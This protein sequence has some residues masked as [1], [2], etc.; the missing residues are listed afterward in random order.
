MD[1]IKKEIGEISKII[2]Q[3][4][5]I[6]AIKDEV[7]CALDGQRSIVTGGELADAPQYDVVVRHKS[8]S[9]AN[10][11]IMR[12]LGTIKDIEIEMVERI[13]ENMLGVKRRMKS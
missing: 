8:G 10:K 7:H 12:R 13:A 1:D 2:S 3:A 6:A 11:N 9:E 4:N 5:L